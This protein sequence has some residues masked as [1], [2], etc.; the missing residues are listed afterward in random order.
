M[1]EKRDRFQVQHIP[2]QV[3][4]CTFERLQHRAAPTSADLVEVIRTV[5]R[6]RTLFNTSYSCRYETW[7]LMLANT[8]VEERHAPAAALPFY[9]HDP[10]HIKAQHGIRCPADHAGQ[11]LVSDLPHDGFPHTSLLQPLWYSC[12]WL[13]IR[14]SWCGFCWLAR[15]GHRRVPH[16]RAPRAWLQAC[17]SAHNDRWSMTCA[18]HTLPAAKACMTFQCGQDAFGDLSHTAPHPDHRHE[19]IIPSG[20]NPHPYPLPSIDSRRF[21]LPL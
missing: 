13:S 16:R 11:G 3:N 9:P 2:W 14:A 15:A 6:L 19:S 20:R 5:S 1:L 8:A 10:S 7:Q 21:P 17:P 18:S 12:T 4:L